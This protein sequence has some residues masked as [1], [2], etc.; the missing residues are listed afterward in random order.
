MERENSNAYPSPSNIGIVI[1]TYYRGGV[2][3]LP[4]YPPFISFILSYLISLLS[5]LILSYL[6]L[7]YFYKFNILLFSLYSLYNLY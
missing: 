6:I 1:P 5:Y 7:S 4:S 3:N 2:T